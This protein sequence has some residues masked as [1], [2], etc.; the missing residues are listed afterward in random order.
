MT[1]FEPMLTAQERAF[2]A[3]ARRAVLATVRPNGLPRLVPI[4]FVLAD[5][6]IE[7]EG[8]AL[9][10]SALDEKPK[11]DTDPHRL[12]RVADILARPAVE[13]LVDRWS[14][15][16]SR[17]GWVRLSGAASLIEPD[18]VSIEEHR[19]GV[20]ALREKYPQYRDQELESRPLLRIAVA[21]VA[22]WGDLSLA[23]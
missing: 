8:R 14:E 18:L 15:D 22:R 4:C 7:E 3:L 17:L 19:S 23:P 2:V 11:I 13:V 1:A 21:R 6:G 16:W 5:D 20:A 9:L 12:A 10:Y